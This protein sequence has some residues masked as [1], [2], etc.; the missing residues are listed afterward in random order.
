MDFFM[1]FFKFSFFFF[2]LDISESEST[3][4]Q[5]K[6]LTWL[7]YDENLNQDGIEDRLQLLLIIIG[8]ILHAFLLSFLILILV[9]LP[10][11]TLIRKVFLTTVKSKLK[12]IQEKPDFLSIFKDSQWLECLNDLN[13]KK[14]A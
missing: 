10:G 14:V 11:K 12:K 2:F 6:R 5:E 4:N 8:W 3:A 1:D 13:F 9:N 7:A